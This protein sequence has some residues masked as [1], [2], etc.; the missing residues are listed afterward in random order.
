MIDVKNV[1]KRYGNTWVLKK[2]SFFAHK[3]EV[4]GVI[5]KNGSGKTTLLKI[6]SGILKPT[7]GNIYL[8]SHLISYIPEKPILIP[9]LTLLENL[10]YFAKLRNIGDEKIK[11]EISFFK[12]EEHTKKRP[13]ELSKGLKQRLSMAISLLIEPDIILLDEPTSGLDVESKKIITN[14]IL[15]LKKSGKTILYITHEDEEV[16]RICDRILILENGLM[17]FLGT[18]EE[19]WKEYERFVYVTF[20][21]N[22]KTKLLRIEDLKDL[23]EDFI[24][25]RS[26]G[27]REFL[28]GGIE[29]E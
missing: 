16:E 10:K 17:K 28:S 1:G 22:K 14:K 2:V 8:N 13:N 9:E 3:G 20:S 21:E 25:V 18:I 5:G 6:I 15:D 4:I 23:E 27:I 7:E 11:H 29:N 26:I 12:L 19:F 24:H